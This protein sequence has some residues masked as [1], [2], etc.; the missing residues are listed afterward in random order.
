M[1]DDSLSDTQKYSETQS[2]ME[3]KMKT[4][5]QL[6]RYPKRLNT[7]TMSTNLTEKNFS[8]K[9][10]KQFPVSRNSNRKRTTYSTLFNYNKSANKIKNIKLQLQS[11]ITHT[12][13]TYDNEKEITNSNIE[14]EKMK[15]MHKKIFSIYNSYYKAYK[16]QAAKNK[17]KEYESLQTEINNINR[18]KHKTF[19]FQINSPTVEAVKKSNLS[20]QRIHSRSIETK[21]KTS[22]IKSMF[23]TSFQFQSP[24]MKNRKHSYNLLK[25]ESDKRLREKVNEVVREIDHNKKREYIPKVKSKE[26]RARLVSL[27]NRKKGIVDEILNLI[28]EKKM[29]KNDP[30]MLVKKP[31]NNIEMNKL[32]INSF[33]IGYSHNEFSKKLYDLNEVFFTLLENMKVKRTEIDIARFEKA[34]RKYENKDYHKINFESYYQRNFRDRWEKKFMLDQ[35]EYRIPEKEFQKFKKYERAKDKKNFIENAKKL[36]HLITKLDADEYE[37]PDEV[38]HNYRSTK[39]NISSINY[40]RISRLLKILKNNEDEEQTGNIILKADYLKKEQRINEN[41]MINIIGKSGKPR[42]VKNLFKPKTVNKYKSISGN[43]FGLPV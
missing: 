21:S 30:F 37:A 33:G 3:N 32:I 34:K 24:Q 14:K 20:N 4:N 11:N 36:S 7:F 27:L 31:T 39:S 16:L 1:E 28:S 35:Y 8:N 40:K 17:Q 10:L 2:F 6:T 13:S 18:N 43:Y 42:F 23:K 26:A 29:A 19:L 38:T 22:K 5:I 9:A 41:Q 12:L 15:D 25:T